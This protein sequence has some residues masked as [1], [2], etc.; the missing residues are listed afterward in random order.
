MPKI[1]KNLRFIPSKYIQN[2]WLKTRKAEKMYGGVK[3]PGFYNTSGFTLDTVLFLI[4]LFL[5]ILGMYNLMLVG[6][7][8]IL[9]A[10]GLIAV[11][12]V[13]AFIAHANVRN[14]LLSINFMIVSD[15]PREQNKYLQQTK[16]VYRYLALFGKFIIIALALFK[17][18][19]FWGLVG[20]FNG[21]TLFVIVT[22]IV[23]AYIHIY[24]TG[25]FIYEVL[26]S[27]SF[28]TQ[29]KNYIKG[30]NNN[31]LIE[32]LKHEV[33]SMRELKEFNVNNRELLRFED[34]DDERGLCYHLI[35]NGIFDDEDV[36]L[37]VMQQ[38][39]ENR[40]EFA[41][42]CLDFQLAIYGQAN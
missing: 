12:I 8:A 11:D 3:L 34:G 5:E 2:L 26:T 37:F 10:S 25:Y 23:V 6:D 15:N 35:S 29:L 38:K 41:R 31:D 27:I 40:A 16:G 19:S 21:L 20:A 4:A 42:Q 24:H 39:N 18:V 22:Y 30:S 28:N 36:S 13:A 14:K 17:I 7:I 9:M 32:S 1:P 33:Y